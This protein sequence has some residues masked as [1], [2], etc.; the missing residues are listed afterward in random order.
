LNTAA[1]RKSWLYALNQGAT[2]LGLTMILLIWSGLEFHLRT[3]FVTVQEDS[4]QNLS[5]LS[6]AFEEHLI[7]TLNAA[8]HTLQI[9]RNAY[10][11][12][13]ETFDL[14]RWSQ[15]EHALEGPSFQIVIIGPNGFMK[16]STD[17]HQSTPLDLGDREHFR[18][19][20]DATD[21]S[22]FISK[23]LIGRV[24]GKATIQLSRR[25][26]NPNGT[27]GGVILISVDPSNFTKFYDAIDIGSDGV[28]RVVGS[29]GTVRAVG[30]QKG[31]DVDYLGI[32]LVG[33]TLLARAKLEP[34]GWYFTEKAR[35]DGIKRLVFYRVVQG[36]PLIVTVGLGIEG[37]FA[38]VTAKE[39]A[40]HLGAAIVT[41]LILIVVVLS[42]RDRMKLER[43]SK[44]LQLQARQDALTGLPNRLLFLERLEQVAAEARRSG[45][46]FSVLM[47]DLDQFKVI[48]DTLGHGS[49]DGL[50]RA[51]ARRLLSCAHTTDTVARLGGDE[52]A[53]LQLSRMGLHL[54]GVMLASD[55]IESLSRP[56]DLAGQEVIVGASVGIASVPEHGVTT[57][58]LLANADLALYQSKVAGRNGYR[59][60]EA[61]M[62]SRAQERR[63]LELD[64]RHAL[65]RDELTLVYQP[66]VNIATQACSCMEALLRWNRR[67]EIVPPAKFI[68]IAED[69][70]LIGT[71]G[72]WVLRTACNDATS[73]PAHLRLAVNLSPLQFGKGDLTEVVLGALIRSGLPSH[74]LALEVT[75]S[76]LL[77][78]SEKN[79]QI[80]RSLKDIGIEIVLDDFG[81]GYS[82]LTYLSM[83][84][85]N[86]VKIDR[87]FV[88]RMVDRRD[89]ATIVCSIIN[90]AHNLDMTTVAEGVETNEQLA[91]LRV[92][93]CFE[94]QGYLFSRP[95]PVSELRFDYDLAAVS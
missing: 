78:G 15:A 45:G 94:A 66:V 80:L 55:I 90:L 37:A 67:G 95:S 9:A 10:E 29:D 36:F 20:I 61:S 42:F 30:R 77:E 73:W 76:V 21:D 43:T 60:F 69:I 26:A 40:Y 22:L 17:G 48:N 71:I 7:R 3:E 54:G 1:S 74:R 91:M 52:F 33:S 38:R 19:H 70:G 11:R 72:E 44:Q 46:R 32:S 6:R 85:F 89:C 31:N 27:F 57:D 2:Y 87:S 84:P 65:Q 35:T 49:G 25:I 39:F 81:T 62:E 51:V 12:E 4:I 53:I 93:G 28:I 82:S 88:S 50:L 13:P 16:A 47:I 75:E 18:I 86:K 68:P 24:T 23:P 14:A 5:N 63:A 58:Q 8:D 79:L 34:S 41:A 59:V 92:A 64:L 83:F 56:Y